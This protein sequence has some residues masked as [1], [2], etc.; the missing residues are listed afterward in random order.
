M[1]EAILT[2]VL[3]LATSI[4]AAGFHSC[5][6]DG[7]NGTPTGQYR[8]GRVAMCEYTHGP[9]AMTPEGKR[10]GQSHTWWEPCQ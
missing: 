4:M 6:N 7:A 8:E 10:A 2:V 9:D 1:K 5:P 3:I